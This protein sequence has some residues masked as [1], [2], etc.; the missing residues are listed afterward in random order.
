MREL[1]FSI[2]I[3]QEYLQQKMR[4]LNPAIDRPQVVAHATLSAWEHH[5][6]P[7]CSPLEKRLLE[8]TLDIKSAETSRWLTQRRIAIAKLVRESW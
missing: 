5:W 8:N 6:N 4:G 7:L 2:Q 1:V 3:L